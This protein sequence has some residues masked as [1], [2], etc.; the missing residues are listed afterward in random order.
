[1]IIEEEVYLEHYGKKGMHWG[2]RNRI[3]KLG[4]RKK[5]KRGDFK[6]RSG[7]Q[8][9]ALIGG[10]VAGWAIAG[11]VVTRI[12]GTRMPF[13]N[14][15]ISGASAIAGARMTREVLDRNRN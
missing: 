3:D 15:V 11:H 12:L 4:V 9:A 5:A 13:T 10:G 7:K 8:K 14:V 6:S 1:M 2:I